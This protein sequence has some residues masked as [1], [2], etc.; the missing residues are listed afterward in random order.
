MG[1]EEGSVIYME[2][3]L[4]SIPPPNLDPSPP[5]RSSA[6]FHPRSAF[7][8][9]SVFEPNPGFAGLVRQKTTPQRPEVAAAVPPSLRVSVA[10]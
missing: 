5:Q 7:V 1:E 9:S 6:P 8:F 4:L 2:E 3:V 10:F